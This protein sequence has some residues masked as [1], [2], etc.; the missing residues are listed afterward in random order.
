MEQIASRGKIR[1]RRLQLTYSADGFS[2]Q[3]LPR[4]TECETAYKD[5]GLSLT[6]AANRTACDV[7][8]FLTV[9]E[10]MKKWYPQAAKSKL[11]VT[12]RGVHPIEIHINAENWA[13][14][15]H[16]LGSEYTDL[17]KYQT[18]LLAHEFAHSFG[19]DHV[20]CACVGCESDVRQQPSRALGG[21][22]PTVRV[23]FNPDSPHSDVNF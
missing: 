22:K 12:D 8:V 15:P 3:D 11:S 7:R 1:H 6:R 13:D 10:D 20:S 18:A 17:K 9:H 2:R 5:A 14:I 21:C 16:H 23:I 19:H 4:F